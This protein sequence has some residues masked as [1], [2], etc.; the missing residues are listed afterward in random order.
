VIGLLE[1]FKNLFDHYNNQ[2]S[3]SA[4]SE[5]KNRRERIEYNLEVKT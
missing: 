1:W 3:L 2:V 4:H 5:E